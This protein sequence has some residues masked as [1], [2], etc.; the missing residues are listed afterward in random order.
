M[1]I[2]NKGSYTQVIG[3]VKSSSVVIT[4][5]SITVNGK[6]IKDLNELDEKE[7]NI[8]IEGD[9]ESL[10]V[11]SCDEIEVKGSAKNIKTH[12]GNVKVNNDVTGNVST[13]NGNVVCGKVGGDVDTHNGN[14][15]HG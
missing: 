1:K 5:G 12:N 3:N 14:I 2:I 15:I 11:D 6:L 8:I 9:V 13:H 7:I 4:N 10:T